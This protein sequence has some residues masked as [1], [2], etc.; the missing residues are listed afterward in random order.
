MIDC[1]LTI[2]LGVIVSELVEEGGAAFLGFYGVWR[3][4]GGDD[5]GIV[6]SPMPRRGHDFKLSMV[7]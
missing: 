2:L 7:R 1:G 3:H 5:N 6:C 4:D